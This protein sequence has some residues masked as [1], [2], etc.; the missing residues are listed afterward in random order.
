MKRLI[1]GLQPTGVLHLGNY[2]GAVKNF[3]E[4][5]KEYDSTIFIAD[6][7]SIT[8]PQDPKDLRKSIL[9]IAATYIAC[10]VDTD[11]T[12]LFQQSKVKEH[13]QLGWILN[14]ITPTGW[15]NRMTQFKDKSKKYGLDNVTMGLYDYPVLMA[16]DILA[17]KTD[18]VPVGEDQKQHLELA[19]DIAQL[20]NRRYGQEFFKIPDPIIPKKGARVMSLKDGT[21][22]M[23]KSDDSDLT[24][25]NL[26]DTPDMILKK[27]K[28]AKTDS[29][30]AFTYDKQNRPELA[31]LLDIYATMSGYTVDAIID[32]YQGKGFGDFKTGL[33]DVIIAEIDPIRLKILELQ[34]DRAYLDSVLE[35]GA[36][37]AREVAARTLDEVETIVGFKY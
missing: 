30:P 21:K 25:I 11:K 10:G 22:K 13:A 33:A 12:V 24:R 37:Q 5:Q 15:L 27:C 23:S 9:N 2:I 19:R 6:M 17:H 20:F 8:V 3:V 4:M 35:K 32:M 28:K 18:V 34:E 26:D 31:N 14:C 1:S 16:A 29:S 7:H 36:N